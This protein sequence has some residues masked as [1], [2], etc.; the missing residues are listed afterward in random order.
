MRARTK[1]FIAAAAVVGFASYGG[2]H[3]ATPASAGPGEAPVSGTGETAY[4]RAVLADLHAPDTD[5]DVASVKEWVRHETPWPPVAANNP[6][7]ST[8]PEPGATWF[9]TL[10]DGLHVQNYPN[11]AEGAAA[12]AA[13]IANGRYPHILAG[14]TSGAGVC[15]TAAADDFATWSGTYTSVC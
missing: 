5:A 10:P 14:L 15:G 8:L 6:L 1:V 3:A 4:I 12:T 7:D 13:T 9:N 2:S 11:A